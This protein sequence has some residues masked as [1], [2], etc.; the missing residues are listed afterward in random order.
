MADSQLIQKRVI[1]ENIGLNTTAM[2]Q[3]YHQDWIGV[4]RIVLWSNH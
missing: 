3:S 1:M 4:I 2:N